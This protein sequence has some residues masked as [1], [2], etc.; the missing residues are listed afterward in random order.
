MAKLAV[1]VLGAALFFS[2]ASAARAAALAVPQTPAAAPLAAGT[3]SRTVSLTKIVAKVDGDRRWAAVQAGPL[4]LPTGRLAW[5]K[6]GAD[7]PTAELARVFRAEVAA[8]GFRVDGAADDLF[9]EAASFSE[10]AV[11]GVVK[12]AQGQL[13]FP[14]AGLGSGG[15][16]VKGAAVL[17]V[18]WQI[19]SRLQRQVVARVQTRAGFESRRALDGGVEGV[20]LDA[21]AETVKALV[22]SDAFRKTF[23]GAPA[24]LEEAMKP[25]AQQKIALTGPAA[26]PLDIGDAV[27]AVVLVLAGEGHGSGFLVSRDGYVMTDQHVVGSAKLV[28]VRWPDGIE[29]VGEVVRADRLRDVALV[30]TDP[31]GRDPL[32]LRAETMRPGETVFAIGAPLE[33]RFQGTV[34]RGVV[35]AYRTIEGLRYL[36]SDVSIN[37]GASGGP[38]LDERGEVVGMTK[39]IYRIESAPTGINFFTPTRDALDFLGAAVN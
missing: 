33:E 9:E 35:S 17:E 32:P 23:L 19:Y 28:T 5:G 1:T 16:K 39:S 8:A 26:K 22:A 31:R 25:P 13:C 38:L 36:Q 34:T 3:Q 6:S 27:G 29:T 15:G 2:F 20:V 14:G 7:V 30:K 21:F 18:E 12:D 11:A 4:C 24:T 10:Y 37:P